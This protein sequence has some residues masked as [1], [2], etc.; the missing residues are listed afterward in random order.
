MAIGYGNRANEFGSFAIGSDNEVDGRYGFANGENNKVAY[1]SVAIG[2]SNNV[3][4]YDS[5][6]VGSYNTVRNWRASAFGQSNSMNAKNGFASGH[7]NNATAGAHDGISIRGTYAVT[8]NT[9]TFIDVVGGGTDN[10]HR[11]NASALTPAGNYRLKGDIFVKCDD[12]SSNGIN[13][14][15]LI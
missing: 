8:Q 12:N 5:I 14:R 11:W 3:Y 9:D 1:S 13:L 15:A 6:A 10:D 7:G 4:G 2:H